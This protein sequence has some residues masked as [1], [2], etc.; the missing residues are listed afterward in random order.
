MTRQSGHTIWSESIRG[1]YITTMHE[2]PVYRPDH[3]DYRPL[4]IALDMDV[5]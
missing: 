5:N 2:L 3:E 1:L 4:A